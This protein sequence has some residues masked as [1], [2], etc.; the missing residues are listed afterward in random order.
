[1]LIEWINIDFLTNI[2]MN[3]IKITNYKIDRFFK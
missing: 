1:M 3:K 2:E